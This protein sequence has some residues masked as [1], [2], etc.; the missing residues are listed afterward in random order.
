MWETVCSVVGLVLVAIGA[1]CDIAAAIGINRFPNF[2]VSSRR[3]R[4]SYRWRCGAGLRG[5]LNS[6]G[7]T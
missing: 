5:R 3:H 1:F 4:R 6:F 7:V 2:F